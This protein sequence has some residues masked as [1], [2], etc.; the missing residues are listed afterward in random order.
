MDTLLAELDTIADFVAY[1][2][3]REQVVTRS[4]NTQFREFDLLML[5]LLERSNGQWGL[6][7]AGSEDPS[8]IPE[9]LWE[10]PYCIQCRDRSHA[11]NR[12]SYIVDRLIDHFHTE[13]VS[14]R[15]LQEQNIP[16]VAHEEA[17]RTMARESRFAH[18]II[19]TGIVDILNEDD[20]ST[21]WASTVESVEFPGVRYVWLAYPQPSKE[22][23]D[24]AFS[25]TVLD[26]LKDHIYVVRSIFTSALLIGLAFPNRAATETSYF[27]VVF[28]GTKWT[29]DAQRGA[30]ILRSEKGILRDLQPTTRRHV[31]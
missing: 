11:E 24:D 22:I 26:H 5:H 30:E 27:L 7:L 31:R 3:R 17:L 9:G 23:D 13:Y 6:L 15:M 14:G 4:V 20:Q 16:F 28:D 1:L 2:Y 21:F 18:R 10:D 29:E 8:A 25:K 19:A 12:A